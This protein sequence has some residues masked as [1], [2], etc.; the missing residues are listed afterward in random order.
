[1]L[2]AIGVADD[3]VSVLLVS[4]LLLAAVPGP[5]RTVGGDGRSHVKKVR[6]LG[7][8]SNGRWKMDPVLWIQV[9]LS[10]VDHSSWPSMEFHH[11]WFW[12]RSRRCQRLR[13][14]TCSRP[15]SWFM[16]GRVGLK[17]GKSLDDE[18]WARLTLICVLFFAFKRVFVLGHPKSQDYVFS[19]FSQHRLICT[20]L[21]LNLCWALKSTPE[22][23]PESSQNSV[24]P[25][26]WM[27]LRKDG[28]KPRIWW[29]IEA[30]LLLLLM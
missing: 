19:V 29:W 10:T 6:E 20:V 9:E 22:S 12:V 3:H 21:S 14:M 17:T 25:R 2:R 7:G 4:P 11:C 1:M 18:V 8:W 16:D 5:V 24:G 13:G 26:P 23:A 27:F 28:S 30:E 15:D